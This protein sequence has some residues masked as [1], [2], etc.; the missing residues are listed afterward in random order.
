MYCVCVC[1]FQVL[2][3]RADGI[4]RGYVNADGQMAKTGYFPANAVNLVDKQ[5]KI[6]FSGQHASMTLNASI[7]C[8]EYFGLLR[9]GGKCLARKIILFCV[10]L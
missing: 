1:V 2:E 4:W 8:I 7:A 5:S 10:I 3:Q 9:A 6:S